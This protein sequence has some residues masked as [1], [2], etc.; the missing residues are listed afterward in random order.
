MFYQSMSSLPRGM[1]GS[2]TAGGKQKV[3]KK[4]KKSTSKDTVPST[5]DLVHSALPPPGGYMVD[6]STAPTYRG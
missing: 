2:Y 4:N 5:A 3:K 6:M 1:G